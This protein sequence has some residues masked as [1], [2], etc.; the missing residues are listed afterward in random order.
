MI[1]SYW[2]SSHNDGKKIHSFKESKAFLLNLVIDYTLESKNTSIN[3]SSTS[4]S[5]INDANDK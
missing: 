2:E 4:R 1:L 5:A 3:R